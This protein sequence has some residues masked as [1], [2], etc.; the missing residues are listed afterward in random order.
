MTPPKICFNVFLLGDFDK[1]RLFGLC[2]TGLT[3]AELPRV[4][5]D[6]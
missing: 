1:S 2:E 4:P 5:V 3:E 6:L